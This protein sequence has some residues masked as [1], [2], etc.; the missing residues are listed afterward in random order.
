M[1]SQI[2][3]YAII[4]LKFSKKSR[5]WGKLFMIF[6]FLISIVVIS[7]ASTNIFLSD[8]FNM[9]SF[10][11]LLVI[12]LPTIFVLLIMYK[13]Q[14]WI[15]NFRIVDTL[16]ICIDHLKYNNSKNSIFYNE[17]SYIDIYPFIPGKHGH[18][19]RPEA[20]KLF[21]RL[22]S[23]T[24][25]ELDVKM[26]PYDG[27]RFIR[28]NRKNELYEVFKQLNIRYNYHFNKRNVYRHKLY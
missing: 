21:I 1:S 26:R 14:D 12:G 10:N 11:I 22:K 4:A 27:K 24:S 15:F 8:K 16:E 6:F 17:I 13:I 28:S 5:L 7:V 23:K 9:T 18:I 3:Q 2:N 20:I 19:P 25:I